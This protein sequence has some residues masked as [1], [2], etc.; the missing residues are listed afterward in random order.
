MPNGAVAL[1]LVEPGSPATQSTADGLLLQKIASATADV[2][3]VIAQGVLDYAAIGVMAPETRG[4]AGD[5]FVKLFELQEATQGM[6]DFHV[7]ARSQGKKLIRQRGANLS[8][9][10]IDDLLNHALD[11]LEQVTKDERRLRTN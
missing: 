2:V 4:A 5:F 10:V 11:I 3:G 7:V 6:L 8:E 9:T 1:Q